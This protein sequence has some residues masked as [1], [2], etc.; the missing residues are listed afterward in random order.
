MY[1]IYI[2]GNYVSQAQVYHINLYHVIYVI[3]HKT[4]EWIN[5]NLSGGLF[6][7]ICINLSL[8]HAHKNVAL[9]Y[10]MCVIELI[11]A[12]LFFVDT[13]VHTHPVVTTASSN[14]ERPC[15]APRATSVCT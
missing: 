1:E 14:K 6:C 11:L 4:P 9:W 12:S 5:K 7:R 13:Q 15:R 8:M 10:L 3:M 2:S